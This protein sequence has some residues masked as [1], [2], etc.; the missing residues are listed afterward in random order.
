MKRILLVFL[1][2]VVCVG[3]VF[4]A[5]WQ[6]ANVTF[7][8]GGVL[9]LE[10][11]PAFQIGGSVAA[12]TLYENC[13]GFYERVSL[14]GGTGDKTGDLRLPLSLG[15][16]FSMKLAKGLNL[17]VGLGPVIAF[18]FYHTTGDKL[19]LENQYGISC[20]A[21]VRYSF[22]GNDAIDVAVIGGVIGSMYFVHMTPDKDNAGFSGDIAGYAGVSFGINM[23]DNWTS[24]TV[25]ERPISLR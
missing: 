4:A 13:F 12:Y 18:G 5:D 16:A 3:G 9:G 15:A 23:Q 19:G 10:Y 25:S 20:D 2:A 11:G 6:W 24:T 7:D 14:T 17:Y 1:I 8:A 22:V 21:G